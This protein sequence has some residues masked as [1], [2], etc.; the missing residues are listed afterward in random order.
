L[1]QIKIFIYI[2]FIAAMIYVATTTFC[3]IS[4]LSI[5]Y[6]GYI[7]FIILLMDALASTQLS[8]A[9][10]EQDMHSFKLGMIKV[11]WAL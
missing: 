7:S 5:N 3:L 10:F 9:F 4:V 11:N 6:Y 8:I 1:R 2:S